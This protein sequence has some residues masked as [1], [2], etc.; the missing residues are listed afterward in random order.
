MVRLKLY[1]Y[2]KEGK[3]Q[4]SLWSFEELDN[5]LYLPY[6]REDGKGADGDLWRTPYA[7]REARTITIGAGTLRREAHRRNFVHL[8]DAHKVEWLRMVGGKPTWVRFTADLPPEI[9]FESVNDIRPLKRYKFNLIQSIGLKD[10]EFNDPN[11]QFTDRS[12]FD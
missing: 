6:D 9:R 3:E 7:K 10:T 4:V 2:D 8:C 5:E 12:R 1:T 11:K